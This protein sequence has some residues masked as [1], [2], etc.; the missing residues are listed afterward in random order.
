[1]PRH[2]TGPPA[3]ATIITKYA[4]FQELITSI[5]ACWRWLEGLGLCKS[6]CVRRNPQ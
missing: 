1:M 2:K 4:E 3:G 6:R 5:S